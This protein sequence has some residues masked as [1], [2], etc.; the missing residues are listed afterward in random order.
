VKWVARLSRSGF[1][2]STGSACSRGGGASEVLTAM[3]IP[4]E[5]TGAALRI[6]SGWSTGGSD[7][8]ALAARFMALSDEIG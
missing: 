7:W 1:Q 2:V 5:R 6:S 3:G 8:Q 4:A